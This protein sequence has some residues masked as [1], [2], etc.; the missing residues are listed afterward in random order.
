MVNIVVQYCASS[1]QEWAVM[2]VNNIKH[3]K[4][5]GTMAVRCEFLCLIMYYLVTAESGKTL[6]D[7]WKN[8]PYSIERW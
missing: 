7:N 2:D 8:G 1:R 4:Q 3:I 5:I 6:S